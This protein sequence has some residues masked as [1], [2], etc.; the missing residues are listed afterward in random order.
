MCCNRPNPFLQVRPRLRAAS[1][2]HLRQIFYLSLVLGGF[3][4]YCRGV[5]GWLS[6]RQKYFL[7]HFLILLAP[8]VRCLLTRER[9]AEAGIL[10]AITLGTFVWASRAD[11]G[12]VNKEND[13]E[14]LSES[15]GERGREREEGERRPEESVAA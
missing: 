3:V 11:P 15:V 1:P 5:W 13:K 9:R 6:L 12:V 2:S 8:L 14:Y 10:T 7:I 4:L